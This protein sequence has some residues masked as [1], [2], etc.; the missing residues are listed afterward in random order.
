[1]ERSPRTRS[2]VFP[3]DPARHRVPCGVR[4]RSRV[5]ESAVHALGR[6]DRDAPALRLHSNHSNFE[7][8]VPRV[9][10]ARKNKAFARASLS[11]VP[12]LAPRAHPPRRSRSADRAHDRAFRRFV[13]AC[14]GGLGTR[15]CRVRPGD[16]RFTTR[17]HRAKRSSHAGSVRPSARSKRL[18][19]GC[20]CRLLRS[21]PR[22]D[23][24][25][26]ERAAK[27]A[28]TVICARARES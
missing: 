17:D 22:P 12:R 3:P 1:V 8:P 26:T 9:L 23:S 10:P 28:K 4:A 18:R 5:S 25:R 11:H 16:A 14:T 2:L 20:L 21:A 19:P 24:H 6:R 15:R 13:I 27:A 7:S